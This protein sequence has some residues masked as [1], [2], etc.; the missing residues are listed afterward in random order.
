MFSCTTAG[1]RHV[2]PCYIVST[3]R[4]SKIPT[5]GG[6]EVKADDRP[7]PLGLS[8]SSKDTD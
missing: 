4:Y 8:P 6:V 5:T 3:S 2:L 1:L 7:S